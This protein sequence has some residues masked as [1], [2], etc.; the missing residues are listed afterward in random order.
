[1]I[2]LTAEPFSNARPSTEDR[3]MRLPFRLVF[4]AT[5]CGFAL[6]APL[7]AVAPQQHDHPATQ[8]PATG[9]HHHPEAAKIKNPVAA[10]AVSIAA[11]KK[12]FASK[13]AECHGDSGKG[14][15]E[16]AGDYNPKPADL[17]DAEWKH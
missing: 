9:A 15:G 13:C 8:H 16:M 17:T 10:D 14:D 1:M 4:L 3:S 6:A 7:A 12:L 11:G 5:A 2:L